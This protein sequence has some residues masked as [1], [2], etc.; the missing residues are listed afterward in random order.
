MSTTR[1][2]SRGRPPQATRPTS[3]RRRRSCGERQRSDPARAST[4]FRP[5]PNRRS[6]PPV[7]IAAIRPA[8]TETQAYGGEPA[9]RLAVLRYNRRL[10]YKLIAQSSVIKV[11]RYFGRVVQFPLYKTLPVKRGDVVAITVPTWA[12]ILSVGLDG[13][14]AWRASRPM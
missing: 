10:R 12:P 1:S 5:P 9:I 8:R 14:N 11:K 3:R 4:A 2:S 6:S 13:D 7:S